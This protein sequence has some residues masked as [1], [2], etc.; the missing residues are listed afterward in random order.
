MNKYFLLSLVCYLISFTHHSIEAQNSFLSEDIIVY[1]IVT[2]TT[3]KPIPFDKSFTLAVYTI[4]PKDITKINVHQAKEIDG[5]RRLAVDSTYIDNRGKK[6]PI[7]KA[8]FSVDFNRE[9]DSLYMYFPPLKPNILFDINIFSKLSGK[10][11]AK[12]LKTNIAAAKGGP[13]WQWTRNYNLFRSS[14]I[15]PFLRRSSTSVSPLRYAI[16]YLIQLHPHYVTLGSHVG[17]NIGSSL[18]LIDCQVIGKALKLNDSKF[19]ET[20]YL[21]EAILNAQLPNLEKGL[22]NI[23]DIFNGSS[24]NFADVHDVTVRNKNLKIS[25]E[26]IRKLYSELLLSISNGRTSVY[27][28]GTR[29]NLA[30]IAANL[31]LL[32]SN[33]SNNLKV[34]SSIEKKINE[35][36]D[37]V[38]G[39]RYGIYL[40]AN[41]LSSDLKT[42]GGNILFL[43]AG[44]SNIT[45]TGLRDQLVHIPKLY[46]GVSIYFRPIDKNT[47]RSKFSKKDKLLTSNFGDQNIRS[48]K[49]IWSN[50]SLNVGLTVG[51]IKV[52]DFDNFINGSSLLVGP[53]YRISRATKFSAGLS[54]LNRTSSNPLIS[55][56]GI[57]PGVYASF[58]VDIDFIQG[59]TEVRKI[60]FK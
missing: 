16:F 36:I 30:P 1:D 50:L 11:R 40:A 9:S 31:K 57:Y 4:N 53:A 32:F 8:D 24:I 10:Q 3:N 13:P 46:W 20:N 25:E 55:E 29:Y 44:I 23:K 59:L 34:I 15:D 47:R 43:D 56:K 37:K 14:T 2:H 38:D 49:S 18:T 33:L 6:R 26:L 54:L 5:N 52:P 51:E 17:L 58:S 60:L 39:F 41:T 42:S 45:T 7:S 12:L 22:I 48:S 27:V 19:E 21:T 28:G 35:K